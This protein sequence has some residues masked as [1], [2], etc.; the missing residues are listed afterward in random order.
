MIHNVDYYN[1]HCNDIIKNKI[2]DEYKIIAENSLINNLST[3]D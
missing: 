1:Y 3:D 2:L